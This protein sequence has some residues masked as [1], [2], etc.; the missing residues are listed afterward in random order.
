MS[1][2]LLDR[3]VASRP[4]E[5]GAPARRAVVRWGVRLFRREWRQQI[6]V[7][8]LLAVAVAATTLGLAVATNATP[9]PTTTFILSGS[10]PQLAADLAALHRA[11]GPA[12]DFA[13]RTVPVPGSVA[14]IE[15]RGQVAGEHRTLRDVAAVRGRLP[16]VAGEVALTRS[17]S[18]LLG[19]RIGSTWVVAGRELRVVGLVESPDRL[20]ADFALVAPGQADP[21]ATV[22]VQFHADIARHRIESLRLP[23]HGPLQIEGESGSAKSA[24]AVAVLAL[25]TIG[26]LFVGLVGVAG[27]SVMAQRRRRALGMFGSLGATDRHVRL[28]LLANGA[29]VGAAA[30]VVG[31]IVGLAAWFAFAPHLA[32]SAGHHIDRFDLPW[33]ALAAALVL[34]VVTAVASSWWPARAAARTSIV[35]ALSGRP[36]RP[37]PAGRFAASGG[38]VLVAGLASLGLAHEQR[39]LLIVGGAVAT[40]VGVLLLAPLTIRAL[41]ALA[42]RA[43]V[44]V[45]LAARDLARHQARSGAALGAATLAVGIAAI[46]TINA[47]S[48]AAKDAR[49]V[50]PL[51]PN[52]LVVHLGPG[53]DAL[54]SDLSPAQLETARGFIDRIAAGLGTHDVLLLTR[55][56]DPAAP[57]LERKGPGGRE[58]AALVKVE[59]HGNRESIQLGAQLYVATPELLARYRVAASQIDPDADVITSRTDLQGLQLAFDP[60]QEIQTPKIQQVDLPRGRSEPNALITTG[61]VARMGLRAEPAA[62]LIH[63]VRPLTPGQIGAA[64]KTAAAGGLFLETTPSHHSLVALGREATATGILLAL[65]VLAMTIGLLRSETANDLRVLTATGAT[66]TTRRT[67][68]ASTTGAL[69]MLAALLGTAESYLALVAFYRSNLHALAHPPVANL[70][71]IVVG[72][73]VAAVTAGWLLAGREPP[74][75]ARRPIE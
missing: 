28:V 38:V 57:E 20:F 45:R 73:P 25:G 53:P 21:P 9:A 34:A 68:T 37:Q 51:A 46:V 33:W 44:A 49:V 15:L 39:A 40:V 12:D 67:L 65:G 56:I 55:A 47:A 26:L 70:V 23:S 3:P 60:R 2:T 72:L 1:T 13:I 63:T 7:V 22:S 27:F 17:A 43:P 71:V 10:D 62:W 52:E 66:S 24:A 69:A 48:Q 29:A 8:A 31:S 11:F 18:S 36:A 42:R 64:R 50:A 32:R 59:K 54:I 16:S 41:A 6:L 75:I 14:S 19:V 4:P 74:A 30:A 35:A 61:T 58:A 5:G